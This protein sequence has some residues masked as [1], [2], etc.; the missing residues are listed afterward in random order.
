MLDHE[1]MGW[2]RSLRLGD[3]VTLQAAKPIPAVVRQLRPWRERTQILLAV[4][5][6]DASALAVGGKR[7]AISTVSER[8]AGKINLIW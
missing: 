8:L 6:P 4:D 1:A 7:V 2:A 5:S 3:K